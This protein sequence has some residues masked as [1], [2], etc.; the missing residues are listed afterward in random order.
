MTSTQISVIVGILSFYSASMA[1]AQEAFSQV[2]VPQ[3]SGLQSTAVDL[4]QTSKALN[5]LQASLP[6]SPNQ[7]GNAAWI[8]QNGS[9]N[10][11]QIGQEAASNMGF[12]TQSGSFNSASIQQMGARHQA[13][14]VQQ[15][16]GNTALVTQR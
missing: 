15:G 14:V 4:M 10:T 9:F 3:I 1:C 6:K 12:I 8:I 11:A 13:F 16:I 2:T 7:A 5:A